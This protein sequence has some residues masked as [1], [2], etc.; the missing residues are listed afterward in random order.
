[1][2]LRWNGEGKELRATLWES[3]MERVLSPDAV[4]QGFKSIKIGKNQNVG[5]GF[6]M[7]KAVV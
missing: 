2:C 7:K 6:I 5:L 4:L 3:G 1:M